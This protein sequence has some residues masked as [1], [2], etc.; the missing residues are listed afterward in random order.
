MDGTKVNSWTTSTGCDNGKVD[1]CK[2]GYRHGKVDNGND[3]KSTCKHTYDRLNA[4]KTAAKKKYGPA[5]QGARKAKQME[6]L[7]SVGPVLNPE[8]GLPGRKG[9]SLF[10]GLKNNSTLLPSGS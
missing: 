4:V 7:Q 3:D 1:N 8:M 6:K 5:R 2:Y 10:I 9:L